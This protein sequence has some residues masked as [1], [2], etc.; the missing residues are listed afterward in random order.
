MNTE[1]RM[2]SISTFKATIFTAIILTGAISLALGTVLHSTTIPSS[3]GIILGHTSPLH[4][5]GKYIKDEN[6]NIVHL[7]GVC[8]SGH[9][10]V[11]GGYWQPEGSFNEYGY[12]V[13]LPD[14][15]TYNL[16]EMRRLGFTIVR[17]FLPEVGRWLRNEDPGIG[18]TPRD[19][20]TYVINEANKLG[21]YVMITPWAVDNAVSGGQTGI[22]WDPYTN[23]T[24][25]GVLPDREAFINYWAGDM[26][27]LSAEYG[28]FPNV[29]YELWNEPNGWSPDFDMQRMYFDTCQEIVSR[30]RAKGDEHLVVYQFGFSGMESNQALAKG[31]VIEGTNIVYAIHSY[32]VTGGPSFTWHFYSGQYLYE[33]VKKIL[34]NTGDGV[35]RSYYVQNVIDKEVPLIDTEFGA[36]VPNYIPDGNYENECTW[37]YNVMT[38]F[39]EWEFGYVD[40]EWHSRD[41]RTL[42]ILDDNTRFPWRPP[43][44]RAGEIL[45][46][47]IANGTT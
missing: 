20:I 41:V 19:E 42:G 11:P 43:L 33:D 25:R 39:N 28:N 38:C 5:E 3:G 40:F 2:M 47:R 14:A 18:I 36:A 16:E 24:E 6:G 17:V 9:I 13:W 34:L 30:L 32:R 45:V 37:F 12:G 21:M 4:V 26:N 22:P 10:A 7:R 1:M 27:S 46:E 15:V 31:Q 35:T 23:P 8:K 29:I 44:I